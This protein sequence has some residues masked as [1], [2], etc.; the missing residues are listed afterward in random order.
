MNLKMF[1]T[2]VVCLALAVPALAQV[3][4]DNLAA[5]QIDVQPQFFPVPE[6]YGRIASPGEPWDL[7]LSSWNADYADPWNFVDVLLNGKNSPGAGGF[8]TNYGSFDDPAFNQRMDDASALQPPAR[9]DAYAALDHDLMA[10]A[11]PWAPW[12]NIN[13]RDFF[14]ARIGCQVFNPL[15]GMDSAALCLR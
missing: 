13:S 5:I 9:Y 4:H 7:A 3:V 10:D 2:A 1:N 14:S 8:D 12:G 11:A 15:F 6:F